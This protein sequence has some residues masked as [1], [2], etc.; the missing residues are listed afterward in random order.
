MHSTTIRQKRILLSLHLCGGD[1]HG[2]LEVHTKNAAHE[3]QH[4]RWIKAST[5][6]DLS[7]FLSIELGA[8]QSY[9]PLT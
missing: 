7:L 4:S 9:S 3:E 5:T 2:C 6:F 8:E 1:Y